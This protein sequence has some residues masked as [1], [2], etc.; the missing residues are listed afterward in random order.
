MLM[1]LMSFLGSPLA[2]SADATSPIV[3]DHL[4]HH[5]GAPA[6][7]DREHFKFVIGLDGSVFRFSE[8]TSVLEHYDRD[9]HLI[10]RTELPGRNICVNQGKPQ[11]L[12]MA[13]A[14]VADGGAWVRTHCNYGSYQGV[15]K[16]AIRLAADGQVMVFKARSY[17]YDSDA[18]VDPVNEAWDRRLV[19]GSAVAAPDGGYYM[20]GKDT[21][22]DKVH[23]LRRYDPSGN[24]LWARRLQIAP[25]SGSSELHLMLP[26]ASMQDGILLFSFFK[27]YS[28]NEQEFSLQRFDMAGQLIQSSNHQF[29]SGRKIEAYRLNEFG[30]AFVLSEAKT[31]L[32]LER[33]NLQGE[34]EYQRNLATPRSLQVK[35]GNLHG[36]FL[37]PGVGGSTLFGYR[38]SYKD[39]AQKYQED[40]QLLLFKPYS[41]EPLQRMLD[42]TTTKL[43]AVM[44]SDQRKGPVPPAR[45]MYDLVSHINGRDISGIDPRS[46]DFVLIGKHDVRQP[47]DS[48]TFYLSRINIT[49]DMSYFAE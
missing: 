35:A 25:E 38:Q 45:R 20:S 10:F 8:D 42:C 14:P 26:P 29:P 24:L 9:Y 34:L 39:E 4:G 49:Q 46:G 7:Y 13:L 3:L 2:M 21:G 19:V 40:G 37:I 18:Y 12:L 41:E 5:K 32:T 11:N 31:R 44:Y 1:F 36:Y 27:P 16:A 15:Q 6:T 22:S 17:A 47:D 33:Y 43:R 48:Y 30:L 28:D 23:I